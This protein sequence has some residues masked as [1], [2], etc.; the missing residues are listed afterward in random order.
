M[1]KEKEIHQFKSAVKDIIPE[2]SIYKLMDFGSQMNV[3]TNSFVM[4]T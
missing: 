2:A 4:Q 1:E 3:S